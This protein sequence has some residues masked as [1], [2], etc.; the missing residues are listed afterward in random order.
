M[1]DPA[2]FRKAFHLTPFTTWSR[3]QHTL[4]HIQIQHIQVER[5]RWYQFPLQLTIR[6]TASAATLA[7]DFRA[8]VSRPRVVYSRYGNPYAC[9]IGHVQ[10]QATA[11]PHLYRVNALGQ[12]R[13]IYG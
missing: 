7:R 10:V 1:P 13:R 4:L 2:A 11:K 9:S 12:G 3:R 6:S 8:W 5:Y